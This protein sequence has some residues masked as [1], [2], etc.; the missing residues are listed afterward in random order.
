MK[1]SEFWRFNKPDLNHSEVY[2]DQKGSISRYFGIWIL[3]DLYL[4]SEKETNHLG[5]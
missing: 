2:V 3:V 1:K 5:G 4:V